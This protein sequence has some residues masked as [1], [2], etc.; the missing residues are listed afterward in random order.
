MAPSEYLEQAVLTPL[1]LT[2]DIVFQFSPERLI[3]EHRR[4]GCY[5]RG[6][7]VEPIP[8]LHDRSPHQACRDRTALGGYCSASGLRRFYRSVGRTLA[9]ENVAGL[10]SPATLRKLVSVDTETRDER[11]L[12]RSCR[13]VGGFMT[14][15]EGHGFGSEISAL[16]IGH[17]GLLGA[18]YGFFDP[19]HDVAGAVIGNGLQTTALDL[20]FLRA[21]LVREM[22]AT[23]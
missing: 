2:G 8:L 1:G 20:D 9:G 13:F 6:L 11:L 16:A 21:G 12:F 4:I 5:I 19:E 15:L 22:V 14:D 23:R 3:A 18:S 10:P 17:S 7:P